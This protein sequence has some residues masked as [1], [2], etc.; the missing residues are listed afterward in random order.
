MKENQMVREIAKRNNVKH[1]E[2]AR[3]L[4]VSEQTIMRWLRTQ[5]PPDKE[6]RILNAI[7]RIAN[8]GI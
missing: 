5:L 3:C 1:W 2:I 4:G 7:E 8:G 6:K